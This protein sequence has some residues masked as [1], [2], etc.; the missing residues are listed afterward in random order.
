MESS[1]MKPLSMQDI[2]NPNDELAHKQFA[3]I[4][5]VCES[6][7]QQL[8]LMV[9]WAKHIPAFIELILDDQVALLRAHA[10]EHLLLGLSRRSMCMNDVL[11]LGNDRILTKHCPNSQAVPNFDISRIGSR[12]IDELIRDM[13]EINIDDS[14]LAC[15]KAMI[16]FDPH[17]SGLKEPQKVKNIRHLIMKNLEDYVSDRQYDSW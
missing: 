16:I 15:I 4:N 11:L 13:K 5:D 8:I 9:E 3:S 14:E 2:A 10:G 17:V 1:H 7:K 6:M 12:I